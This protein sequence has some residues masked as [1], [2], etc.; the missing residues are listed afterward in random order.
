MP[1][2]RFKNRRPHKVQ[3]GS[4]NQATESKSREFLIFEVGGRRFGLPAAEVQEIVR[5]VA[6][7][8]LPG[9]P[10]GV[11]GVINVRGRV[12][13]VLDLRQRFGLPAKPLEHTDHLVIARVAGRLAALR[14]DRTIDLVRLTDS[15][16]DEL[17][18]FACGVGG[19][20]V[21][22]LPE[23]MVLIHDDLSAFLSPGETAAL[24]EALA[25]P[26]TRA[27]GGDGR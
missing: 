7:V 16:M 1:D 13:P 10:V 3:A 21:A 9:A 22:R 26:P 5:A 15:D 18:G 20:R 11:E 27:P 2:N 24:D 25:V 8:L 12:V 19:R 6:V 17:A 23:D 4:M 14:V